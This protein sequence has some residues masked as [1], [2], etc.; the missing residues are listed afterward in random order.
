M[1]SRSNETKP[2]WGEKA[3]KKEREKKEKKKKNKGRLSIYT[4]THTHENKRQISHGELFTARFCNRQDITVLN[5]W[6]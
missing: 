2:G 6:A 4:H 3:V 5:D 1:R